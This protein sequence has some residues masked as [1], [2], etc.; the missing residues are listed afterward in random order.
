M[1]WRQLLFTPLFLDLWFETA[2]SKGDALLKGSEAQLPRP[3][4]PKF[5]TL[6]D[7]G[8]VA[9][10]RN[11]V[12]YHYFIIIFSV[13]KRVTKTVNGRAVILILLGINSDLEFKLE[14]IIW[15]T[16]DFGEQQCKIKL[17]L[18]EWSIFIR[19]TFFFLILGGSESK[20]IHEDYRIYI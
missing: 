20:Q 11:P 12:P 1:V 3:T 19:Y 13:I 17:L 9:R 4:P 8:L 5:C 16:T 6:V 2:W 15:R 10:P 14:V 7:K 18:S